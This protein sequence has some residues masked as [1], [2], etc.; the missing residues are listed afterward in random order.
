VDQRIAHALV[1]QLLEDLVA[2]RVVERV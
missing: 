1:A 2:F